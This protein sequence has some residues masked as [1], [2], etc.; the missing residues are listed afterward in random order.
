VEHA[1]WQGQRNNRQCKEWSRSE[2][3]FVS[4]SAPRTQASTTLSCCLFRRFLVDL[5][6]PNQKGPDQTLTG[7]QLPL[8]SPSSPSRRR[9]SLRPGI[10]VF[11]FPEA[12]SGFRCY[13]RTNKG[14]RRTV[15]VNV[16]CER[17][18]SGNYEQEPYVSRDASFEALVG[19]RT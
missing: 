9:T 14:D 17:D 13:P 11:I 5:N 4:V 7:A 6:P 18:E 10:P 15:L 19:G 16:K 1:E 12:T 8:A 2:L 3:V